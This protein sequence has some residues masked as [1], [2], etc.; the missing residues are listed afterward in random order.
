[1][2]PPKN[3]FAYLVCMLFVSSD[4]YAQGF[5]KDIFMDGGVNLT[6]RTTLPASETLNLSM[7]YLAT[8]EEPIQTKV[9]IGDANDLNGALLYPDGGPRFRLLYTNGGKSTAHGNSLGNEGRERVRQFFAA[10]ET[11]SEPAPAPSLPTSA[12][13][14]PAFMRRITTCGRE[15]QS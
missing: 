11:T 4:H 12:P 7:E 15:G 6:H 14:Q 13:M 5:Y 10:G 3:K 1:M 8:A 2:K 9:M